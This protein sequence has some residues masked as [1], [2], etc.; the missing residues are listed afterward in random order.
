M[1]FSYN[2]IITR[3]AYLEIKHEYTQSLYGDAC[4]VAAEC[5]SNPI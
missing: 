5:S 1:Y 4:I 2:T 3:L